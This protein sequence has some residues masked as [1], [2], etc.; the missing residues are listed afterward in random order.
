MCRHWALTH[1]YTEAIASQDNLDMDSTSTRISLLAVLVAGYIFRRY[2]QSANRHCLPLPPGPK[3]KPLIGNALD[4]PTQAGWLTYTEWA[5]KYESN[6]LHVEALGQ[7]IV[8]LNSYKDV[9]EIMGE[10]ASNYSS[11]PTIPMLELMDWSD[12]TSLLPYGD[13]WRSHRHVLEQSFKKDAAAQY[14]SIQTSK[15][16]QMLRSLLEDPDN[17]HTHARIAI[18]G[19]IMAV[20]YGHNISSLDDELVHAAEKAIDAGAKAVL[21]GAA[22]VNIFPALRH[23]PPWLPGGG[24]HQI[25]RRVKALTY[26]MKN[27]AFNM[28]RKNMRDGTGGPSLLR[29]LLEARDAEG[30]SAEY[31]DILK[32]AFATAYAGA[33][34]TTSN[35]VATFLLAMA[36]NPGV[37]QKAQAEIDSV[38]GNDRLPE[39]R[40]RPSLPYVE[41]LYREVMRWHPGLPLGV[42][43]VSSDD[44][45]YKGFLIPKDSIIFTNIWAMTRDESVYKDPDSFQPERYFE[46]GELNDDDTVLAFGFG[47]RICVGQYLASSSIW[48][49][50]VNVLATLNIGKAK[51]SQGHDI[52]IEGKYTSDGLATH[53]CA[54]PCSVT[55]RSSKSRELIDLNLD[56]W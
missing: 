44:D 56:G 23:I 22:L 5:K 21:P 39:L 19:T 27:A 8:I 6:I 48:L 9:A 25:G 11:H 14:E 34:E 40:D 3:P 15:T 51:D 53:P 29:N 50:I 47:K 35:A 31:E 33:S 20:I 24:F 36:T 16:R 32:N 10:R 7:H 18:I 13:L 26:E 49:A 46:N 38:I 2:L 42:P 30:G 1:K 41:A 55:P 37:Q 4:I 52:E 43:H 28:V 45:V 12:F 54:F 17:L